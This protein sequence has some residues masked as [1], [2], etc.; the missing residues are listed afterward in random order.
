VDAASR[1]GNPW[2][3]PTALRKKALELSPKRLFQMGLAIRHFRGRSNLSKCLAASCFRDAVK[4]QPGIPYKFVGS[5]LAK[6]LSTEDRLRILTNH[7]QFFQDHFADSSNRVFP[8]HGLPVWSRTV[9]TDVFSIKMTLPGMVFMEGDMCLLF[10]MN[11][12]LLHTMSFSFVPGELLG[13]D[14]HQA[15]FIG[16]SQGSRAE[17]GMHRVAAKSNGEISPATM[18]LLN[19]QA[20]ARALG[21][22]DLVGVSAK[23]HSNRYISSAPSIYLPAYDDFWQTNGGEL[24]NSGYRMSAAISDK[25][26]TLATSSHRTRARRK[27]ARKQELMDEMCNA[28]KCHFHLRDG[29]SVAQ[30]AERKGRAGNEDGSVGLEPDGPGDVAGQHVPDPHRAQHPEQEERVVY[31]SP[32]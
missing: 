14:S 25:P 7:F 32:A 26:I 31:R 12:S 8:L 3:G 19:L 20:L 17:P 1:G 16:G 11:E 29:T 2:Y 5:Y 4:D 18:L 28:L 21:I 9:G 27:R 15:I 23:D 22:D 24:R 10:S 13:V 6:F 30:A